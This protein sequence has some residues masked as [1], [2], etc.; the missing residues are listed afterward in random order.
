MS[1]VKVVV[2]LVVA[3]VVVVD[4]GICSG[5]SS[6]SWQWYLVAERIIYVLNTYKLCTYVMVR[7]VV[8]SEKWC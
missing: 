7:E 2:A 4:S 8:D 1:A 6:G 5:I 3:L